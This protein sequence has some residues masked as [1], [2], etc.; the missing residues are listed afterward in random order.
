MIQKTDHQT[1]SEIAFD[2][3]LKQID[4]IGRTIIQ[5]HSSAVDRDA[6]FPVESIDALKNLKLLSAYIPVSLGGMGLR[7]TQIARI[8]EALGQYCGSTAMIYAMHQIQVACVVHHLGDS[9]YFRDYLKNVVSQQLVMASATTELGTG[10]D[11]SSSICAISVADGKFNLVKQSPV[12]SY[13]AFADDIL[14]TTR[15]SAESSSSDQVHVL[16]HK[17][18]CRLD[19]IS[20]WDTL[21][22]RGTCSSGYTLTATGLAVQI[23]PAPFSDILRHTMHPFAHITWASLWLGIATDAVG[24]ARAYVRAE[25]RKSPGTTPISAMRLAETDSV[26]QLMRSNVH[27]AA[28]D[29]DA[30]I[31]TNDPEVFNNFGFSIR[32]NNLKLSSSQLIVELVG[33]AML[34]CGISGYR[35]DSKYSLAQHLRDA[36]GAALMV[37]NDRLINHNA[38]LLMAY[39]EG[40]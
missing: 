13:G 21:G 29:Y 15:R 19:P 40:K 22:F 14:V 18:D 39:K 27:T 7:V 36:Y 20:G 5:P 4:E 9:D 6:R 34:I 33:R 16:V 30:M 32:T 37:N 23:L 3:L 11:L 24:R 2:S 26:L 8:C 28:Q 31:A 12:I 17:N 25:A 10:G 38:T 1:E 35:N